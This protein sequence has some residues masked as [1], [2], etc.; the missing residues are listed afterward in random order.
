MKV[1]NYRHK[2]LSAIR[3]NGWRNKDLVKGTGIEHARFSRIITGLYDPT[4]E[5]RQKISKFLRTA[6]KELF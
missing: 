4:Q 5:E 1:R 6:Q 2:L 3:K